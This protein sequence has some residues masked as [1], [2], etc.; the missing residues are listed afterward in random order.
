MILPSSLPLRLPS[1]TKDLQTEYEL[2]RV[3]EFWQESGACELFSEYDLM[4]FYC[5]PG[6]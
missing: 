5:A 3:N 1:L 6:L 4:V 2:I